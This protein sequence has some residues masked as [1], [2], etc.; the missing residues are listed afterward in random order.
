M[1]RKMDFTIGRNS[2]LI[3]RQLGRPLCPPDFPDI[4]QNQSSKLQP[5]PD[6]SATPDQVVGATPAGRTR[7]EIPL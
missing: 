3:C 1:L 7:N 5:P 4:P 6:P 2:S